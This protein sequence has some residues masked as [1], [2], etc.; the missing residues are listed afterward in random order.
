MDLKALTD[1][2]KPMMKEAVREE[3][4]ERIADLE[5]RVDKADEAI[6]SLKQIDPRVVQLETDV[7][8]LKRRMAA[9]E[10]G[11]K[12]QQSQA[13]SEF[14]PSFI[15]IKGFCTWEERRDKGLSRAQVKQHY[16]ELKA[17]LPD[18]LRQH[19]KE[20]VPSGLFTCKIKVKVTP[21]HAHDLKA[22]LNDIF[23]Q[24]QKKI[25]NIEPYVVTE[26]T[27]EVQRKF[28]TFG[29][30]VD[31]VKTANRDKAMEQEIVVEPKYMAIFLK[32]HNE[33]RPKFIAEVSRDG[34][35]AWDDTN[36]Q[37]L[38][39]KS[40]KEIEALFEQRRGGA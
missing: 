7:Q 14:T 16:D 17:I 39:G 23:K 29:K 35:L 15:E 1:A 32:K 22:T 6:E 24:G 40:G 26:R 19:F 33:E 9:M 4:T 5:L 30:A 37:S 34:I 2:L 21:G 3:V 8:E 10:A 27:P 38:L 31:A 36:C 13:D 25:N 18:E 12:G 20:L 11:G 28:A